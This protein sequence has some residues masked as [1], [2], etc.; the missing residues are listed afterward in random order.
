MSGSSSVPANLPKE[1]DAA[2]LWENEPCRA[3]C[4]VHT[5]AGAY[6]TAI[7]EG[8][9]GDAYNH[10]RERNPFPSICGRVCAAPCESAC[11][12]GTIDAPISIRALKRFVTEKFGIESQYGSQRW[13]QAHGPVPAASLPSVG[14]IGGGPGGL[15]AAY[16]LRMLGHPVTVY[17]AE[18]RLGG[19]MLLGIPEYRL[20][21]ELILDECRAIIELG[22]DVR[23]NCRVGH[24]ISFDEIVE[25]HAAVF[26]CCGTYKGRGLD[27][28]GHDL[29]GVITA[30]DFLVNVNR[31][32]DFELGDDVVVVGGGNVAFDAAR[33][34][35]R[36]LMDG[37]PGVISRA[38]AGGPNADA[39]KREAQTVMD[40]ARQAK[41]VGVRSVTVIALES[42]EELPAALEELEE[43]EREGVTMLY[44]HGPH[45]IVGDGRVTGIETIDVVSVFDANRRFAPV[46]APGTERIIKADTVILAVGQAPDVSFIPE[47]AGIERARFGGL[48]VNAEL[49][50]SHPK[51]WAGGDVAFGPR[52]LIDA[53]GDGRRAAASI[54]GAVTNRATTYSQPWKQ[55]LGATVRIEL[56][57]KPLYKR[58][59]T[60]YDGINRVAIPAVEH[61]KR[62]GFVEVEHGYTEGE[63]MVEGSRCLR[64]YENIMLRPE[65]CILC[66]LCVDVCPYDCISI[67][68]ADV[69][70]G[71]PQ[72]ALILD[73]EA[74][75]RC[76]LCVS[77][78]PPNALLM[79][80]AGEVPPVA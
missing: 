43:G 79:V 67:V 40:A 58:V 24:D 73:E 48:Q 54:H 16:E 1:P 44:R 61:P 21:R 70:G 74:C 46:F 42:Y 36:D 75:I 76:G 62:A 69:P 6:V 18:D 32:R 56:T 80:H 28:P 66:G 19:M 29:P 78:C 71:R 14:V 2:W 68:K 50:T 9:F 20:S 25:R 35:L 57:A 11:R 65:L 30:V 59:S 17:E 77:R 23:F 64:C 63:A 39:A 51:V 55:H 52:N 26:V 22:I 10:A 12:R 47:S 60:D 72:S 38:L 31:G 15:G 34:S 7:G 37:P 3:A 4:P 8:R 33:T 5:D 49:R 53:I 41:R 27:I 13:H 45:R